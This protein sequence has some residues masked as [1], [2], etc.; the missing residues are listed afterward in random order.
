MVR[1]T[2]EQRPPAEQE[3]IQ[4]RQPRG[5]L[6]GAAGDQQLLLQQQIFGDDRPDA[7]RLQQ[8]SNLHQQ[9]S[10]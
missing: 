9:L 4:C 6:A 3:S 1:S 8:L 2:K 7:A 10:K 5:T